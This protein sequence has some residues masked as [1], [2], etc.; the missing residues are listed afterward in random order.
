VAT[1]KLY[2]RKTALVAADL[3]N[4]RVVP[5]FEEHGLRLL[6]VLTDRGTPYTPIPSL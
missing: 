6:R 2:D 4:D 3:L 1:V 5:L